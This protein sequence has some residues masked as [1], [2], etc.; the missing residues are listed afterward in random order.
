VTIHAALLSRSGVL[1]IVGIARLPHGASSRR[2]AR[3]MRWPRSLFGMTEHLIVP[4][5]PSG[6]RPPA[7]INDVDPAFPQIAAE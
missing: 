1:R 4:L 6:V 5:G 3:T 2:P 7:A